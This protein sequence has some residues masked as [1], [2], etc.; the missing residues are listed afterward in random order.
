MFEQ[1]TIIGPGLLGA[2]LGMALRR[3]SV[4]ERTVVWARNPDRLED[5]RKSE[6]CDQAEVELEAALEGS[7]LVV[8]CTPVA[9]IPRF[10]SHALTACG[11]G[12]IVTDVGSVKGE[13]C[14]AAEEAGG[15]GAFLGS[16]P[17]AGSEKSGMGF[18]SADLF[19]DRPCILTPTG[20]TDQAVRDT[21][22]AFW[23]RLGMKVHFMTPD[24]HDQAFA[25]LSHLPHLLASSLAH[26]L[27]G[28]AGNWTDL[29]GKGLLDTTRIAEGDPALWEQIMRM[30]KDNL[31][32]SVKELEA[33]LGT[34]KELIR[35][36]DEDGLK[37]FLELGA[38]FRRSLGDGVK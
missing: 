13:I 10:V 18:A 9:S 21:T 30:N 29:S 4:S 23:E 3:R 36:G 34:A 12:S 19:E 22:R 7:E 33:S 35:A 38:E 28:T 1:A 27:D 20:T 5:C 16:H 25:F 26:C 37:K 15:E 17:I 24:E 14:R 2:S 11:T 8:V 31:L 32:N 6:W